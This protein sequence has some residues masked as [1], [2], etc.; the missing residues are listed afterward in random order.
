MR[1][2]VVSA[3]RFLIGASAAVAALSLVIGAGLFASQAATAS[4][5]P[6]KLPIY[7]VK[8]A[9]KKIALT[10]DAAWGNSDTDQL[11]QILK[12]HKAKA[13]FFATG[14]WVDKFPDDVKKLAAAGHDIQNHSDKHPHVAKI[15]TDKLIADT[16][17]CDDK[18]ETLT[19][20]RPTLY[21]AP[22]GEYD[23]EM[24]KVFS[25]KLKHQVVQWNVDSRDWKRPSVE[26][27]IA[28]V[29]KAVA[30]GSILL[31]HNDLPNTP[32][33]LDGILNQLDQQGYQYILVSDLILTDN[34]TIDH[35]GMQ[36][37]N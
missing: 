11:I 22:Y 32:V 18:I 16:K 4:A 37:P 15:E 10:F 27:M 21:R 36:I 12:K 17:A 20:K 35:N 25:S 24:M 33:A 1:V 30:P 19:G 8:T 14:E 29:T 26:K 6:K 3:K 31:F 34:Y 9:E 7:S 2:F 13:T 5:Q 23:D 28:S